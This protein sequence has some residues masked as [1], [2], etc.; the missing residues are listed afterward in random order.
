MRSTEEVEKLISKIQD[1]LVLTDYDLGV[2]STL[3]WL[4]GQPEPCQEG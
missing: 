2:L 1:K 4:K 3:K